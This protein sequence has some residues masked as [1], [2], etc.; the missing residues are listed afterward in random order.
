MAELVC[1]ECGKKREIYRVCSH[2]RTAALEEHQR[3]G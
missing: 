3:E 1:K 2:C